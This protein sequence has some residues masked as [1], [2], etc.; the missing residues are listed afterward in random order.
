MRKCVLACMYVSMQY[1]QWVAWWSVDGDLLHIFPREGACVHRVIAAQGRDGC[2][3]E[4]ALG[5]AHKAAEADGALLTGSTPSLDAVETK[6]VVERK[7]SLLTPIR[8][9]GWKDAHHV[10][11]LARK[12]A[13]V[14]PLRAVAN[15]AVDGAGG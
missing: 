2:A 5:N 9:S 14:F 1:L 12:H 4:S 15:T 13:E 3:V 8:S 10:Q 6:P 11:M 7:R